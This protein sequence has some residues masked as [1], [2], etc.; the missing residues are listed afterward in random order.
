MHNFPAIISVVDTWLIWK[1]HRLCLSGLMK[2]EKCS[3]KV[4]KNDKLSI[5][6]SPNKTF[7]VSNNN[8]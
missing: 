6:L 3:P 8:K 1:T 5:K 4:N 7:R 2:N